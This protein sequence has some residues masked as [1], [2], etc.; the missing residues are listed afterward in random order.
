MTVV[1]LFPHSTIFSLPLYQ[2][3]DNLR[4]LQLVELLFRS[5]ETSIKSFLCTLKTETK[6]R[7][8]KFAI[9]C[10]IF[11]VHLMTFAPRTGTIARPAVNNTVAPIQVVLSKNV[12]ERVMQTAYGF[13]IPGNRDMKG[14]RAS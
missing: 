6:F 2:I 11:G 10:T 1:P 7:R 12:T 3:H 13:V 8:S 5:A 14:H 4:Q 9:P